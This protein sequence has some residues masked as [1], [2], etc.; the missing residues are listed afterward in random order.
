MDRIDRIL[1][2]LLT[3]KPG[4]NEQIIRAIAESVGLTVTEVKEVFGI[5]KP[6]SVAN[7]YTTASK[8]ES[9]ITLSV[10]SLSL[11]SERSNDSMAPK[12]QPSVQSFAKTV[13]KLPD[14]IIV[15]RFAHMTPIV[16]SDSSD[17]EY[18][19][20]SPSIQSSFDSKRKKSK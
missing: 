5:T 12:L 1:N 3:I 2:A 8:V 17:D 16:T 14:N 18:E 7:T 6:A 4:T 19:I 15:N 10:D 11:V 9:S 20:S 13:T